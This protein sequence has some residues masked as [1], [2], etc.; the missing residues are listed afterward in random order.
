MSEDEL[1]KLK[2]AFSEALTE[3]NKQQASDTIPGDLARLASFLFGTRTGKTILGV[4]LLYFG[5]GNAA[6]ILDTGRTLTNGTGL[7]PQE[8]QEISDSLL[9]EVEAA[10]Q[11]TPRKDFTEHTATE[12]RRLDSIDNDMENVQ[13]QQVVLMENDVKMDTKQEIIQSTV[14]TN[15]TKLDVLLQVAGVPDQ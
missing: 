5:F 8:V 2:E 11:Y 6:A 12:M 10:Q 4:L 3:N 15:S 9:T 1:E 7:T 13:R 14:D